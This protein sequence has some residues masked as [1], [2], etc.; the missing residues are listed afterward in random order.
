MGEQGL[1]DNG[2]L[3]FTSID[4]QRVTEYAHSYV[5]GSGGKEIAMLK[6][7]RARNQQRAW[8]KRYDSLAPK[9][10]DVAQDFE[11]YDTDGKNSIRLSDFMGKKPVALIFGSYT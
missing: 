8:Q 10:G 5:R 2:W 6:I 1:P 4:R 11:L 9:E 3:F 7:I